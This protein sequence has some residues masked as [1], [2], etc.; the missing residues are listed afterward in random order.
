L[1]HQQI[2]ATAQL[3][4]RGG[5]V[6]LALYPK[7]THYDLMVQSFNNTLTWIQDV[8]NNSAIPNICSK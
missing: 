6:E 2:A 3:C 1:P 5:K 4:G 7:A 8:E